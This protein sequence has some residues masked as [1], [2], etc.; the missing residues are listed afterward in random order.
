[1]RRDSLEGLRY[2]TAPTEIPD[3]AVRAFRRAIGFVDWHTAVIASGAAIRRS[4][5]DTIAEKA[6][7]HVERIVSD[8]LKS[9]AEGSKFEVRLRLYAGWYSGKTRTPYLHGITKVMGAYARKV[10][11]YDE[12]RV[13]LLSRPGMSSR[14]MAHAGDLIHTYAGV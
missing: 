2:G 7:K 9:S 10:R 8:C 3:L 13:A 6:L 5:Q 4:R 12:G 14:F 11:T 1:M